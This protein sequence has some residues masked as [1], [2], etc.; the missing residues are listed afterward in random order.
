M[1]APGG[2]EDYINRY[3]GN[4]YS[5]A[6]QQSDA[7]RWQG[8]VAEQVTKERRELLEVDQLGERIKWRNTRLMALMSHKLQ[9]EQNDKKQ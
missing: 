9:Q 7:R 3:S 8:K 1:N 2:V 4:M 5:L 6:Q